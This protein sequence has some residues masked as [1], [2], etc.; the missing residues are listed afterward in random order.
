MI[1]SCTL[2]YDEREKLEKQLENFSTISLNPCKENFITI[3]SALNG[4]LEVGRAV[5]T[6]IDECIIKRNQALSEKKEKEVLLRPPISITHSGRFSIRPN[7][8][9]L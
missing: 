3:M 4:D 1:F 7:R 9:N 8:L 6:F 5:S 2:Y